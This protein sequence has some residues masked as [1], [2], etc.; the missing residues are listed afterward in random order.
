MDLGIPTGT[1]YESAPDLDRRIKSLQGAPRKHSDGPL[2]LRR[3]A[4][5]SLCG[6]RY[7]VSGEVSRSVKLGGTWLNHGARLDALEQLSSSFAILGTIV[8]VPPPFRSH[9]IVSAQTK[10]SVECS[11]NSLRRRRASR[12]TQCGFRNP[13]R[14]IRFELP[15]SS[16]KGHRGCRQ[17]F[18]HRVGHPVNLI[19]DVLVVNERL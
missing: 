13:S 6:W 10:N 16:S 11:R 17:V 2:K 8:R 14:S 15:Q 9:W 5:S 4:T 19:A 3:C 12:S 7:I 18:I 1:G